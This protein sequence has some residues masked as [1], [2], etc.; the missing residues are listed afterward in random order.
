MY[1]TRR[2]IEGGVGAQGE[3]DNTNFLKPN[4]QSRDHNIYDNNRPQSIPQFII[5]EFP[6]VLG[7]WE[8]LR[9]WPL[10]NAGKSDT[11]LYWGM[12]FRWPH[13]SSFVFCCLNMYM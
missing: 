6:P 13:Y 10:Y 5:L 9:F 3:S 8:H 12:S 4:G 11:K 7:Q 1:Y 2:K